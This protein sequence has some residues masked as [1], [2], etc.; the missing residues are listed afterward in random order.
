MKRDFDLIHK[1]L[2]EN[3]A[4]DD[5]GLGMFPHVLPEITYEKLIFIVEAVI[6]HSGEKV[7]TRSNCSFENSYCDFHGIR[8]GTME[9]QGTSYRIWQVKR[10]IIENNDFWTVL[11]KGLSMGGMKRLGDTSDFE[12][13]ISAALQLACD[14]QDAVIPVMRGEKNATCVSVFADPDENGDGDAF[15]IWV[16]KGKDED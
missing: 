2:E 15:H 9:G 7:E 13:T 8:F 1:Y 11:P 14:L 16:K 5:E 3:S 6:N 10:E 12:M 4:L